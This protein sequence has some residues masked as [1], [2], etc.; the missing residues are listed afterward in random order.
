M[1]KSRFA[2]GRV[3]ALEEDVRTKRLTEGL[4]AAV[5]SSASVESTTG[6][7][8]SA[9]LEEGKMIA[10]RW[11]IPAIPSQRRWFVSGHVFASAT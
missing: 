10:A 11:A 1:E 2:V 9:G 4:E 5:R 8:T 7:I 3:T 6:V